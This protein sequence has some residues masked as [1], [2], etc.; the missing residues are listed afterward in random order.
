MISKKQAAQLN[1]AG[2]IKPTAITHLCI[3]LM[4]ANR[5]VTMYYLHLDN[6]L[7]TNQLTVSKVA[8]SQRSD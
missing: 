1:V 2:T 6:Y 4:S 5:P 3:S 7:P 8:D